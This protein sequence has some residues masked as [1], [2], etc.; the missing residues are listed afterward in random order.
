MEIYAEYLFLENFITG[1]LIIHI[2]AGICGIRVMPAGLL[3]GASLCGAYSFVIFLQGIP[4]QLMT[5]SKILFSLLLVMITYRIYPIYHAK[6]LFSVTVCFYLVSFAMGG[7]TI[8]LMYFTGAG[9]ITSKG[10]VYMRSPTYLLIAMGVTVTYLL[11]QLIMRYAKGRIVN[12][13]IYKDITVYM[14]DGNHDMKALIDTGNFL[15]EPINGYPVA[16]LGRA[17]SEKIFKNREKLE[18]R[19]YIVPYSSIG[20]ERGILEG[21]KADKIVVDGKAVKNVVLAIYAGEFEGQGDKKYDLLLNSEL[22]EGV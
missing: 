4:W 10:A 16:I 20:K 12:E 14:P 6:K 21:Y 22:L 18:D 8:G 3:L 2:T 5:A 11:S 9:G 17:A 15:K 1:M 13:R 19:F 7:V